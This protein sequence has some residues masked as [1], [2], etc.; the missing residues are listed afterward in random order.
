MSASPSSEI[1]VS[2]LQFQ[3]FGVLFTIEEILENMKPKIKTYVRKKIAAEKERKIKEKESREGMFKKKKIC[4]LKLES[5]NFF[6]DQNISCHYITHE[7]RSEVLSKRLMVKETILWF[8][9]FLIP[10]QALIMALSH[11][12][13][14]LKQ[15][16]L[17][18]HLHIICI[19]SQYSKSLAL[20]A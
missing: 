15:S 16:K 5:V 2:C 18:K 7:I 13:T 14:P 6:W 8:P 9:L 4:I 11:Y 12:V 19:N 3:I 20:K 10:L 1:D 17:A